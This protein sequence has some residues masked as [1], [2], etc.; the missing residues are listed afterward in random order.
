MVKG[1]AVGLQEL[2]NQ[3]CYISTSMTRAKVVASNQT[4]T[5]VVTH[6][7]LTPI[8][9]CIG[10]FQMNRPP[11]GSASASTSLQEMWWSSL[12]NEREEKSKVEADRE[13]PPPPSSSY[14]ASFLSEDFSEDTC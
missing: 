1:G 9:S 11:T 6:Y 14:S 13:S 7:T 10:K 2:K 3:T 12:V 4:L 5:R 8:S